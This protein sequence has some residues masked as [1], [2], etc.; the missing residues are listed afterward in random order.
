MT[1]VNQIRG[2]GHAKSPVGGGGEWVWVIEW[3]LW[4]SSAWWIGIGDRS[5]CI[6]SV[7]RIR[8]RLSQTV[9]S[10]SV[11]LNGVRMA[12]GLLHTWWRAERDHTSRGT[13]RQE[14]L[15]TVASQNVSPERSSRVEMVLF[16]LWMF[17]SSVAL[18]TVS[19]KTKKI[20]WT[21][22]QLLHDNPVTDNH[23]T[24]D[25][26]HSVINFCSHSPCLVLFPLF[27][28]STS[29][30]IFRLTHFILVPVFPT[31]QHHI[32]PISTVHHLTVFFSTFQRLADGFHF[33]VLCC[34]LTSF[35]R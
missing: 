16:F 23:F 5:Q 4:M 12:T 15:L 25:F 3:V 1:T 9:P 29:V 21:H 11:F 33:T 24:D 30:T 31:F 35:C 17:F 19:Q 26:M 2:V 14:K 6:P 20:K 34:Q 7:F 8:E 28:S 13:P 22:Y 10:A 18:L 27:L 32:L